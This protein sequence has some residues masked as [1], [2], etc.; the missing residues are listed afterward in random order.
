MVLFAD[1]KAIFLYTMRKLLQERFSPPLAT[2][3]KSCSVNRLFICARKIFDASLVSEEI[4]K[5]YRIQKQT[6]NDSNLL[7]ASWP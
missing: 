7:F 3:N 2:R 5:V 4:N 1:K 6:Q